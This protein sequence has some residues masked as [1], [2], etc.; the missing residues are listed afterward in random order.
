MTKTKTAK[1]TVARKTTKSTKAAAKKSAPAKKANAKPAVNGKA[2]AKKLSAARRGR[3]STARRQEPDDDQGDDRCDVGQG[4]LEVARREDAARHA[5]QRDPAGDRREG[6]RGPLQEDPSGA[7]S[8]RTVSSPPL[9]SE[10]PGFA[11][12]NAREGLSSGVFS[13]V[14]A[15]RLV[16]RT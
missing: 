5:L 16:K 14:G 13:W 4:P 3:Q 15:Q 7:S 6:E 9:A 11:A 12:K 10:Y 8:P 1:K 2:K